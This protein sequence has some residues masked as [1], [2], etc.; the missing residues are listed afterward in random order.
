MKQE[1]GAWMLPVFRMLAKLKGLRGTA[2]D[3]FGYTDERKVERALIGQYEVLV[4]ELLGGLTAGQSR[5]RGQ[6]RLDP[7][8]HP[9][10]RPREGRPSREGQ[11]Q[12][13]RASGPVAQPE[14]LLRAAQ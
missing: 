10:L 14:A 2:F 5:P 8:R 1:F 9:G 11:A 12:G 7:R 4:D 3:P 13:G 6:A